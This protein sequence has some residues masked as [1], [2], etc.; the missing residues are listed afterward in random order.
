MCQFNVILQLLVSYGD[1]V[2]VR[3]FL[4]FVRFIL[5]HNGAC[6]LAAL[7][8]KIANTMQYYIIS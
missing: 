7:A 4:I 6:F 8:Y 5:K 1:E 2:C 3:V